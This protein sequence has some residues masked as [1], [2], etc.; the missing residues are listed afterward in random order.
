M[1]LL[2][3]ILYFK[4]EVTASAVS[5]TVHKNKKNREITFGAVDAG[6]STMWV[7]VLVPGTWYPQ[8]PLV[9]IFQSQ[10]GGGVWG[11][12]KIKWS[13]LKKKHLEFHEYLV[14]LKKKN[15]FFQEYELFFML[16]CWFS[17]VWFLFCVCLLSTVANTG[18]VFV[19]RS[20]CPVF[21][22]HREYWGNV[23][24]AVVGFGTGVLASCPAL[25]CTRYVLSWVCA[26]IGRLFCPALETHQACV[27]VTVFSKKKGVFFRL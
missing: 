21:V 15:V 10:R 18:A 17:L 14:L 1:I 23:A 22:S 27:R 20:Y 4:Y 3:I 12:T 13:K 26:F 2:I 7:R 5:G 25:C 19:W 16:P 11:N 8:K 9:Y 24:A 6:V